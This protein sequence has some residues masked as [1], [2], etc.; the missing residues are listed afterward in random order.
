MLDMK[1]HPHPQDDHMN[2][3]RVSGK[4]WRNRDMLCVE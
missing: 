4:I 3:E 2:A 1:H